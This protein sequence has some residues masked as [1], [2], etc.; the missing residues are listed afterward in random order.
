VYLGCG[1]VILAIA[2]VLAW[3]IVGR[4]ADRGLQPDG[5]PAQTTIAGP[6]P[7]MPPA[8][9]ATSAPTSAAANSPHAAGSARAALG[10]LNIWLIAFITG[11]GFMLSG[12]IVTHLVA[13]ATDAGV[14]DSRAANLITI[15]ATVAAFGKV[16][17]GRLADRAGE[18]TAYAV[19]IGLEVIALC[20]LL[21]L[22]TSLALEGI[23]AVL[24][25]GIGGNLPLSAALIARTF[26]PTAFGPMMGLKTMLM[27][28]LV[29]TGT[30]FA[31]WI[32]DETGSYRIAFTVFLG[33]VVL[34]LAAL[35]RV[36]PADQP[37]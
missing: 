15:M 8:P 18:R 10:E 32:F 4:P 11:V 14:E 22:P 6:A 27:T 12:V 20:G 19:A 35:W 3:L 29:A 16:A 26:G 34:S 9:A 30:P 37:A 7:A 5:V 13:M 23:T 36:R 33:L 25:L 2:P 21:L 31:G 24:G 1:V 17:F 28:P